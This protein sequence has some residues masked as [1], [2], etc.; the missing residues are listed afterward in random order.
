MMH[1]SLN[2]RMAD[3]HSAEQT[4]YGL[5]YFIFPVLLL[6]SFRSEFSCSI[7]SDSSDPAVL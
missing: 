3:V 7:E 5:S 1:S 6:V 2:L 4:F